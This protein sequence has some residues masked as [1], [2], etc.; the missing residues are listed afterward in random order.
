MHKI[1]GLVEGG[2]NPVAQIFRSY[3]T[4]RA[5]TVVNDRCLSEFI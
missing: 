2:L 4:E 5:N 3:V 1:F